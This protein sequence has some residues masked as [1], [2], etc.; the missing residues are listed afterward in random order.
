MDERGNNNYQFSGNWVY[1]ISADS[2]F[3]QALS[4]FVV[5]IWTEK[6][7]NRVNHN[8]FCLISPFT[9]F[10]GI[11][12][13]FYFLTQTGTWGETGLPG[14]CLL[15]RVKNGPKTEKFSFR[16]TSATYHETAEISLK[17]HLQ[18]RPTP[19]PFCVTYSIDSPQGLHSVTSA[20]FVNS[21]YLRVVVLLDAR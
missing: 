7:S 11:F 2:T 4:G 18:T 1:L 20:K 16:D 13:L 9:R 10:S 19:S 8:C 21:Y 15:S 17:S 12:I 3:N 6:L 5:L 14:V